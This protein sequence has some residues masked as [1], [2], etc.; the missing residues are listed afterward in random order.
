VALRI[1]QADLFDKFDLP[2]GDS[3]DAAGLASQQ[4]NARRRLMLLDDLAS[5]VL[6]APPPPRHPSL[7]VAT[8]SI[9]ADLPTPGSPRGTSTWL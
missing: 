1:K 2:A 3:P 6:A 4:A 9:S 7:V 8:W 5:L